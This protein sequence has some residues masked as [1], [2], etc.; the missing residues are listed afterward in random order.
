MSA[1]LTPELMPFFGG[2]Y[3][4]PEDRHGRA[5]FASILRAIAGGWKNERDKLVAEGVAAAAWFLGEAIRGAASALIHDHEFRGVPR[6]PGFSDVAPEVGAVDVEAAADKVVAGRLRSDLGV[7][8][9]H[10]GLDGGVVHLAGGEKSGE[11]EEKEA[12]HGGSETMKDEGDRRSWTGDLGK[13][14]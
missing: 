3:F 14:R 8:L 12:G 13:A 7:A 2:T 10:E 4:P 9:I 11:G 6:L 1:W 5:G